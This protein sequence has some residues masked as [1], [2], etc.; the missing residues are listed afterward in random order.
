MPRITQINSSTHPTRTQ[1]DYYVTINVIDDS[2][3]YSST[4]NAEEHEPTLQELASNPYDSFFAG[5]DT[6]TFYMNLSTSIPLYIRNLPSH[7]C[8]S[9][10]NN[11]KQRPGTELAVIKVKRNGT[12]YDYEFCSYCY[13][14]RNPIECNECKELYRPVVSGIIKSVYYSFPKYSMLTP[15]GAAEARHLSQVF[16]CSFC[17][18]TLPGGSNCYSCGANTI[19]AEEKYYTFSQNGLTQL[20]NWFRESESYAV[21]RRGVVNLEQF[22]DDSFFE[23]VISENENP[24]NGYVSPSNG[25]I[26]NWYLDNCRK[27]CTNCVL[28][29]MNTSPGLDESHQDEVSAIL[30]YNYK[31]DPEFFSVEGDNTNLYFGV[32]LE[33]EMRNSYSG[34]APSVAM[35]MTKNVPGFIYCKHDGSLHNGFE[36]VSHPATFNYW[37]QNSKYMQALDGL[38]KYCR[39]FRADSCGIHIHMSKAAFSGLHLA[40]FLH[41]MYNNPSFVEFIAQRTSNTYASFVPEERANVLNRAKTKRGNYERYAIVNLQNQSTIEIRI[42]KGNLRPD[43]FMKNI[44]FCKALYDF[45]NP[46]ELDSF[47]IKYEHQLDRYINGHVLEFNMDMSTTYNVGN[48]IK[49]VADNK[50]TYPNLYLRLKEGDKISGD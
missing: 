8:K 45:T 21:A 49:F 34:V 40:H 47:N 16:I 38:T 25:D 41:F 39:S 42:F 28:Y 9:C 27:Y 29:S 48:F 4:E 19:W 36:I 12:I 30:D 23:A 32:E 26:T 3:N 46:D 10:G 22:R 44:E 33:T 5:N 1:Q 18:D 15:E 13:L 24:T 20:V 35:A 6:Y 37:K 2:N 43:A 11:F 17:I 31:P 14:S 7:Y 50:E